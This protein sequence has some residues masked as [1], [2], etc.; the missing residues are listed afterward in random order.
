MLG[1]AVERWHYT[2]DILL[3]VYVTPLVYQWVGTLLPPESM[4]AELHARTRNYV[5]LPGG[6]C[7]TGTHTHA[8]H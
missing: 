8:W 4:T 5:T 7:G 2:V 6:S 1:Y 3:A